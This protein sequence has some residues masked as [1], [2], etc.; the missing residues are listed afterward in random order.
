[1]HTVFCYNIIIRKVTKNHNNKILDNCYSPRVMRYLKTNHLPGACISY[2]P[3]WWL[4]FLAVE[5]EGRKV[6]PVSD[7][8]AHGHWLPALGSTS[9]QWQSLEEEAD[10]RQEGERWILALDFSIFIFSRHFAAHTQSESSSF[11]DKPRGLF[12]SLLGAY[13][14]HRLDTD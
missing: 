9:R 4:K 10:A 7:R 6:W 11:T 2:C 1:M 3:L 13:T 5:T 8:S 14:S 12:P